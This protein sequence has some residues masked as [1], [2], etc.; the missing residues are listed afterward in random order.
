[1]TK[2]IAGSRATKEF[3]D[4]EG[5][6]ERD[7]KLVDTEL[8]GVKEDGPI[9]IELHRLHASRVRSALDKAGNGLRLLE[10][11]CGGSPATTLLDL[12]ATYTGI[13]FSSTGLQVARGKLDATGTPYVLANADVCNLPFHDNVF[14]AVYSA[15]T[16]YHIDNPEAQKAALDAMLRVTR[17]GGVVVLIAANPRPLL[18]PVRLTRRLLADAP[19]V[20]YLLN[21]LRPKPLL[22]YQ[23][24][25]LG[26]MRRAMSRWGPVEIVSHGI[27]STAFSQRVT[28]YKGIGRLLWR[29]IRWLEVNFPRMSAYLGNYVQVTVAKPDL[30]RVK[31]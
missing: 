18:F 8:F 27:D 20:G 30:D 28:E 31:P 2:R 7:G 19:I 5:W 21:R 16:I 11:G 12:C 3:Y 17:P 1:M 15:H 29:L 10:C 23:P 25:S 9:R 22:P 13:D 4:R 14:D 24:M 6:Q 26:W